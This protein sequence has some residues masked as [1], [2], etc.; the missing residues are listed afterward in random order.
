MGDGVGVIW[1]AVDNYGLSYEGWLSEKDEDLRTF[2]ANKWKK[3]RVSRDSLKI[4]AQD[5]RD[6][7][8]DKVVLKKLRSGEWVARDAGNIP[9]RELLNLDFTAG[10]FLVTAL[11]DSG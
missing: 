3:I 4:T 6:G 2:T 1:C 9:W 11:G 10:A 7:W 8:Q 5:I